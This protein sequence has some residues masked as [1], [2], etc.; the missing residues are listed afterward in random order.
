MLAEL[1]SWPPT[2]ERREQLQVLNRLQELARRQQDVNDRLKELQT[3]LQE[4]RTDQEREEIRRRLKR[5]QEEEQQMLADVDEL[6]QRMDRPENQSRMAEQRKQLDQTREEMQRAAQAAEQ[7]A[8]S[9]ALASGTRAQRQM[10]QLREEMRKESSGQFGEDLRQMRAEARDLDRRQEEIQ[11]KMDSANDTKS[12]SLGDADPRKDL[13]DQL[14]QQKTRLT[15]LVEHATQISQ[16]TEDAEPLV[17]RELYDTLRKFTQQDANSVKD[18]QEELLKRGL[19][20]RGLLERLKQ[21]AE[22]DGARALE[23][24]SE[25]LRQDYRPQAS[26]AGERARAGIADLKRGV[27]RAADKVLGDDTESLRQARQQLEQL[28]DQLEREI[29][30]AQGGGTNAQQQVGGAQAGA[31]TN[32]I[33]TARAGQARAN[34]EAQRGNPQTQAEDQQAQSGQQ[35]QTNDETQRA[36]EQARVGGEQSRPGQQAQAGGQGQPQAQNQERSPS[37]QSAQSASAGQ[38]GQPGDTASGRGENTRRD[39][40]QRGGNPRD[41]RL[42]TSR[43]GADDL[44]RGGRYRTGLDNILDWRGGYWGG[45]ILGEDFAPWSDRLREVEEMVDSPELRNQIALARERARLLRQDFRRDLKKPDWAVVQLQVVKPLVEVR[46]QI[47]D[48]LARREPKD[49]LVPI[50]RDP[51]PNRYSELVRRYYEELGKEK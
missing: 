16:Q 36:R 48:E 29:R 7:G 15:N 10:Q 22:Q 24:T 8:A 35:A 19:M 39:T 38:P 40:A 26:E 13:L 33:R 46:N 20:S 11:K 45:P 27:E 49:K 21:T 34:D 32:E 50:D 25:M 37:D 4:A 43:L 2:E 6:R 18:F 28:T 3:A 23:L 44:L 9:Q 41:N 1:D 14:A 5:L 42:N 51:V 12:K 31:G 30:Q 47:N 17:S